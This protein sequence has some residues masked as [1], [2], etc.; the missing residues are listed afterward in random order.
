MCFH[1]NIPQD[2]FTSAWRSDGIFRPIGFSCPRRGDEHVLDAT[3]QK[4]P[5]ELLTCK[6][7]TGINQGL[8]QGLLNVTQFGLFSP[9]LSTMT[10]QTQLR[11]HLCQ[12]VILTKDISTR[13]DDTGIKTHVSTFSSSF[14]QQNRNPAASPKL[15]PPT[16]PRLGK[17][18]PAPVMAGEFLLTSD[19]FVSMETNPPTGPIK[20]YL[21]NF[22][23][24]ASHCGL[25]S[26]SL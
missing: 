2:V 8:T 17:P 7:Y 21:V 16:P 12:C 18:T 13:R 23:M 19:S 3:R 25:R 24:R 5:V 9:L 14:Q 6:Q 20:K 10:A 1:T 11:L 22:S 15:T 26:G 4:M